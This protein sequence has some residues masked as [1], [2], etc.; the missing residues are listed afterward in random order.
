MLNLYA[1]SNFGLEQK[2][3]GFSAFQLQT[4]FSRNPK[5]NESPVDRVLYG[6]D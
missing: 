5:N 1:I 3:P 2:Y 4:F 6:L